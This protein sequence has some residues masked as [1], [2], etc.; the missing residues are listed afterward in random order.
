MVALMIV[1]PLCLL[2]SGNL[3]GKT[4]NTT[5]AAPLSMTGYRTEKPGPF[6]YW[7]LPSYIRL[8]SVTYLPN[9]NWTLNLLGITHCPAYP[10]MLYSDGQDGRAYWPYYPSGRYPA[11]SYVLKGSARQAKWQ[12]WDNEIPGSGN[13]IA[14]YS[15]GGFLPDHKGTD[16]AAWNGTQVY[17]AAWADEITVFRN[18][19]GNYRVRLRHPNVNG[20]GQRW[21]TF[22][23]H[24]SSSSYVVGS[25]YPSG[26]IYA[27]QQIGNVGLSHLHFQVAISGSY[28]NWAA[29]NPWGID[30]YPWNGC[31]WLNQRSCLY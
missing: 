11:N 4:T 13:T 14:C 28:D 29:R 19:T 16:F 15:A 24:L 26:G 22:Y 2:L 25:S 6:L 20:T 30:Q 9:S 10:A 3:Y 1:L 21:Y 27:G 12:N 8:T 17:A 7:P 31:L 23:D 18:Y 5:T